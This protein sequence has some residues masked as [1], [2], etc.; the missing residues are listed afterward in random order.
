[1]MSKR[2]SLGSVKVG[3]LKPFEGLQMALAGRQVP[4]ASLGDKP[5]NNY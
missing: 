5:G 4:S 2:N 3:L 1:M